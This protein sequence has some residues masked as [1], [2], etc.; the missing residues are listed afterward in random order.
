MFYDVVI[1]CCTASL[2]TLITKGIKSDKMIQC[3]SNNSISLA[4]NQRTCLKLMFRRKITM[5]NHPYMY[6]K[7]AHNW[8]KS[9]IKTVKH[10]SHFTDLCLFFVYRNVDLHIRRGI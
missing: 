5:I 9:C 10:S 2:S 8:S 4:K 6:E 1:N 7:I 3:F